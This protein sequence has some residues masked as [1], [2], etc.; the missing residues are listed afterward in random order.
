MS[1]SEIKDLTKFLTEEEVEKIKSEIKSKETILKSGNLDEEEMIQVLNTLFAILVIEK[2]LE[3]EIEGVEDI[4]EELEQ[5]LLEAYNIYDSYMEKTKKEEKKKK[6]KRFL[7]DFLFLSENIKSK[8][9]NI[10]YANKTIDTM[11]RDLRELKQQTTDQNLKNVANK[12]GNRCFDKFC[13]TPHTCKH[14]NDHHRHPRRHGDAPNQVALRAMTNQ[15]GRLNS[16]RSSTRGTSQNR[17]KPQ[18]VQN[19]LAGLNPNGFN[20]DSIV[21]FKPKAIEG[22]GR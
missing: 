1:I 11:Q 2:T 10:G 20:K 14:P 13:E 18:S 17:T 15:M 9:D 4:R 12:A 16:N 22:K 7:L 3:S 6:K 21:D 8:K 19:V 5:E